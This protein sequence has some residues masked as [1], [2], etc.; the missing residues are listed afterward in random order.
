MA[1]LQFRSAFS[2]RLTMWNGSSEC[3]FPATRIIGK[4]HL[5]LSRI[6]AAVIVKYSP[7]K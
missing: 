1:A 3:G 2:D 6:A 5:R 7:L 4:P